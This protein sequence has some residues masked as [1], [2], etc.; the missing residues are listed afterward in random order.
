MKGRD[1]T[2]ARETRRDEGIAC[3]RHAAKSTAMN[4]ARA[5]GRS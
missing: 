4:R 1:G 3:I 2:Q 5:S